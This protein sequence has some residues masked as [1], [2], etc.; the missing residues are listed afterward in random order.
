MRGGGT[1]SSG[2]SWRCCLSE[3]WSLV[4]GGGTV[5][6]GLSW[7]CCLSEQWSLV[8]GGRGTSL[9]RGSGTVCRYW[10]SGIVVVSHEIRMVSQI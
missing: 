5:S 2:L 4:R 6:S 8:R 3:Q 1:V 9:V 10:L 7:R